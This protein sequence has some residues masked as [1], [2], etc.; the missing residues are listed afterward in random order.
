MEVEVLNA[1]VINWTDKT[2]TCYVIEEESLREFNKSPLFTDYK[3]FKGKELMFEVNIHPGEMKV[4]CKETATKKIV[5]KKRY[6]M[7]AIK[8]W[9]N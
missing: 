4:K 8:R 6:W 9:F 7:W 1:F 3:L 5:Q 2:V